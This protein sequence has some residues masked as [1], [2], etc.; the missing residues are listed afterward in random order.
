VSHACA[1]LTLQRLY[2]T[3]LG[4]GPGQQPN[5]LTNLTSGM[6]F[7]SSPEGRQALM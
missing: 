1:Q 6:W 2:I 4:P 7:F 3:G 5:E